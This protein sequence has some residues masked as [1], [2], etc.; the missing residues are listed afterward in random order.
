MKNVSHYY[1]KV[2]IISILFLFSGCQL[3]YRVLLGVDTTPDW[4]LNSET[5][6]DAK[7]FHVPIESIY[8]L[9]TASYR[10]AILK[11]LQSNLEVFKSDSSSIDTVSI[12]KL[13]KVTNDDLQATQIRFFNDGKAEIFKLVNCYIDPPIPM[14]WNIQGCFNSFPPKVSIESL[15][16]HYY[17]LDFFLSH[18]SNLD[19]DSVSFSELPKSDYYVIIFWNT[20]MKRPSRKLIKTIN[21]YIDSNPE[22][23]I[24][25]IFVNN[26]NAT[27]WNYA[28]SDQKAIIIQSLNKN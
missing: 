13:Y 4:K 24:F 28:N 2:L 23:K 9:D 11:N 10:N 8:I 7:K 14:N 26:Q 17:D 5:I 21:K 27:I 19:G 22:Y 15:N 6:Q 18:I 16:T 1:H 3:S 25:P 20:F 12:K